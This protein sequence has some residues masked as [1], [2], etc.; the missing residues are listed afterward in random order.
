[1][2]QFDFA[3]VFW[4]QIA[5]LVAL[6]AVLYF[7][8]VRATLPRL[9]KVMTARED[10]VSSDISAARAAK[11][12]ADATSESYEAGLAASRE[13]ARA[14]IAEAKAAAA[15][16]GEARLAE[17]HAKAE[18]VIAEAEARIANA[19]AEAETALRDVAAENA[20]SIVTRLTGAKPTIAAARKAVDKRNAA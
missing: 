15:K 8:V 16:A 14:T 19:V 12:A 3:N 17:A 2:P 13:A 5:W 10:K 9:G 18:A 6:F 7:G 20:Q 1:M 4:P 11:E